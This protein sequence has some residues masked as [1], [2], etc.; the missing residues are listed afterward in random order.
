[1]NKP[2]HIC[3]NPKCEKEY[4]ACDECDSHT[5][6]NWRSVA[7][8]I[9]CFKEYIKLI[10]ERD[11]PKETIEESIQESIKEENDTLIKKYKK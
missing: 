9:E 6:L 10:D 5:S 11:N 2:N 8:S 1:M 3:K 4:Y 7:C